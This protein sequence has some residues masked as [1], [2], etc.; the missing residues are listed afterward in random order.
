LSDGDLTKT[1]GLKALRKEKLNMK[2]KRLS[3]SKIPDQ[4]REY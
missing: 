1:T 2:E 4:T 3:N